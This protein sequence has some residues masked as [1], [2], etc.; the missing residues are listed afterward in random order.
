MFEE[1][2]AQILPLAQASSSTAEPSIWAQIWNALAGIDWSTMSGTTIAVIC[3]ALWIFF[4]ILRKVVSIIFTLCV[5][6]L[7]VKY[8]LGVDIL[9]WFMG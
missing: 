3:I 2:L 1:L 5:V 4:K 6:Y 7:A 9:T 8:I